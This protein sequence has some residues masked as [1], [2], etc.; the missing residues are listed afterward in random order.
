MDVIINDES[1]ARGDIS[2]LPAAGVG[3]RLRKTLQC[4]P[5]GLPCACR[6]WILRPFYC[7]K[8]DAGDRVLCETI[9]RLKSQENVHWKEGTLKS[10]NIKI[11][12]S[13]DIIHVPTEPEKGLGKECMSFRPFVF[14]PSHSL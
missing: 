2:S 5:R 3:I 6:R 13:S 7:Q 12:A 10:L 4:L 1:S 8:N 11:S 14:A 9:L